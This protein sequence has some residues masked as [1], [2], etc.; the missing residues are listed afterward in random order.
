MIPYLINIRRLAGDEANNTISIWLDKCNTLRRLDFNPN[1]MIRR[2]ISTVK[3]GGYLPISLE[4][5]KMENTYLY[6]T[7]NEQ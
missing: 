4:R 7:I 5:L 1:Y 6:K 3:R 2:N